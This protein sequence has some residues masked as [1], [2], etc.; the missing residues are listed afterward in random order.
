MKLNVDPKLILS[1]TVDPAN[2][3]RQLNRNN[4]DELKKSCQEF[5]AIFIR[6]LIK[7]MRAT[8]PDGGLLEK[9]TDSEVFEEMMDGEIATQAAKQGEF[10]IAEA[11]FRQ[12]YQDKGANAD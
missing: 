4:P 7:S 3:S 2:Q 9:N 10:G 6:T 11:L 8:V 5:E 12:L 1:Q